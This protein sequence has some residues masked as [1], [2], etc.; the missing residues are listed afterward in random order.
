MTNK[1]YARITIDVPYSGTLV[2]DDQSDPSREA[3]GKLKATGVEHV[4]EY[5]WPG[6]HYYAF[7]RYEAGDGMAKKL[8]KIGTLEILDQHYLCRGEE[9][10]VTFDNK[11]N[12]LK[13]TA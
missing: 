5:Y 13:E 4:H 12:L 1:V 7:V 6:D 2:G 3:Y 10:H 9:L 11:F 8:A